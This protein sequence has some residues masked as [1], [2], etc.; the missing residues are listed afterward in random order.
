MW[1]LVRWALF[2]VGAMAF[3]GFE[4]EAEVDFSVNFGRACRILAKTT[5]CWA[6]LMHKG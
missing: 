6:T 3:L 5:L 2:G 4:T 1:F